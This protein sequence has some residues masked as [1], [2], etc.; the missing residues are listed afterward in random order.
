MLVVACASCVAGVISLVIIKYS[1]SNFL[2][3]F[4]GCRGF[5]AL[6]VLRKQQSRRFL[7]DRVE[8]SKTILV[9]SVI[10]V[11]E[12]VERPLQRV[13]A[14]YVV[15]LDLPCSSSTRINLHGRCS[16]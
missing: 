5:R 8:D 15:M 16:A 6:D 11:L 2:T 14:P 4:V 7:D 13:V 9:G 3:D 1:V 10:R 12:L